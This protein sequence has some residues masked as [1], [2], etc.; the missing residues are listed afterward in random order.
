MKIKDELEIEI[1]KLGTPINKDNHTK[2]VQESDLIHLNISTPELRKFKNLKFEALFDEEKLE[3]INEIIFTSEISDLIS[4][5]L[6]QT[7][8]MPLKVFIDNKDIIIKW[9]YKVQN[10]WHADQLAK[11]YA[12][13]LD[14]HKLFLSDLKKF[15][16]SDNLWARRLSLTSLYYYSSMRKNPVSFDI[17]INLVKNLLHD[18]EYYVQKGV[19]WTIREIYNLYP[20]DVKDFL[21]EYIKDISPHAFQA[22]TEKLDKEFKEELK[23]LRKKDVS[24]PY[25]FLRIKD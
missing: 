1:R 21:K 5:S 13:V 20:E 4:W 22:S 3:V 7:E 10:W 2:D 16:D 8:K 17:T 19:G 18:K 12:D 11:L 23:K 24:N 15:N 9:A 6:I 14:V 25:Q